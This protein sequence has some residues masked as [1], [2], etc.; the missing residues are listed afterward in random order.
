[1]SSF[2]KN[3]H[4]LSIIL[5]ILFG[6]PFLYLIT[7]ASQHIDKAT[8]WISTFI[9]SF[10]FLYLVFMTSTLLQLLL[11][12]CFHV[13]D[14]ASFSLY[15]M[16]FDG[17]LAFH[18]IRLLYTIE[19]FSNSLILNLCPYIQ[20]EEVLRR[21]MKA[22]L[23]IRKLSVLITLFILFFLYQHY[24]MK[25][26]FMFV[27]IAITTILLS[28][29]QYGYFWYGYDFVSKQEFSYVQHYLFSCKGI[30][31]L[32]AQTYADAVL[33]S[34][35]EH[36]FRLAIIE[37]Y[38]YRCILEKR[39]ILTSKQLLPR[40]SLKD[41]PKYQLYSDAK[42]MGLVRL[43]GWTGIQCNDE[44]YLSSAINM[45]SQLIQALYE[46]PMLTVATYSTQKLQEEID[47]LK[48]PTKPRRLALMEHEAVFHC[49]EE[50]L[51]H[52]K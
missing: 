36:E 33:S 32:S 24:D 2:F 51:H 41:H 48:D 11:I 21:K 34:D 31:L 8:V 3:K 52:K 40:L 46:H 26:L 10:L 22:F 38:L 45:L 16:T 25:T 5:L 15:P 13:F 43:I 12:K 14:I 35:E 19:G 47:Y 23:R 39:T 49:Y 28:Y 20:Q 1:M 27:I 17:K 44:E 18:P 9:T 30:P 42:A 37:N 6:T 7:Q 4:C 29:F 50:C